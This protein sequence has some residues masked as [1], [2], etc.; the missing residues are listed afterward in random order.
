[1]MAPFKPKLL[2]DQSSFDVSRLSADSAMTFVFKHEDLM[3]NSK[4]AYLQMACLYT[5]VHG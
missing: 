4:N 3:E 1:M 5:N 2:H